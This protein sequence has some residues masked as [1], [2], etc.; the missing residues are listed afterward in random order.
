VK[1]LSITNFASGA[2]I[3]FTNVNGGST[4]QACYLG[5]KPNGI[6]G[7]ANMF[8]VKIVNSSNNSITEDV[9]SGNYTGVWIQETLAGQHTLFNTVTCNYIGT[10]FT[11][12]QPL[13]NGNPGDPTTGD[14]VWILGGA[15]NNIIGA[16]TSPM[17][18]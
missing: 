14:G 13:P 16:T 4:V 1:G 2:A 15:S 11:G 10:D 6:T 7:A 8:G 9:I 5:V 3:D 12:L 17:G 18:T